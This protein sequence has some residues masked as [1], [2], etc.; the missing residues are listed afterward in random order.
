MALHERERSHLGPG[1]E[2]DLSWRRRAQIVAAASLAIGFG[3]FG[4]KLGVGFATG[5]LGVLSEAAHSALDLAASA[6]AFLAVRAAQKPP[7]REHPYGHGRTENLA[8]FAEGL[9][10]LVTAAGIFY[11]AVSRLA[12]GSSPVVVT[13]YALGLMV[14]SVA[15]ESGRAGVLAAVGRAARSHALQADSKNR[16][17]DVLSSGGVLLGLVGVR[18][19]YRWADAAAAVVVAVVVAYAASRLIW[20]SGDILIDRAPA[21]AEDDLRRTLGGVAGVRQVR[22]VRVRRSGPRLLADAVVSARRT[23]PV[24]AVERLTGEVRRAVAEA[25]PELELTLVVEG[26]VR[27]ENLVERVHAA[28]A[29]E[30]RIRDL[31]NVTVER[32]DDGSLHLVMHAKLPGGLTLEDASRAS[33]ELE[34][35]LREE[36]PEVSRIDVHLE[37]LEPDV[38]TGADV[39]ADRTEVA[40]RIRR[41]VEAHP[42]VLACRDVELSERGGLIHAHVVAQM[43]GDVTLEQAHRVETELELRVLEAVPEIAEIVARAAP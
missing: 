10:L 20:R 33:N 11:A 12:S 19:G 1:W 22:S 23:L 35:R 27:S 13:G 29:R 5:S 7:D 8:A 26:E 31:H 9:L 16:I 18:F 28:A 39:T 4:A 42:E 40:D 15:I 24:E 6:F 21:G 14:A 37:P 34:H 38:V 3:L 2:L 30:G 43:H 41:I 17:T 32:E 36:L 25:M